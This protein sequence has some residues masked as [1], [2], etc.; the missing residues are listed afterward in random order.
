MT[1]H[2]YVA[3]DVHKSTTSVAFLNL[4]GNL[5]TQ[6]V[7]QTQ[8]SA[9]RDSLRGISG[10]VHLTFE[11]GAQSQRLFDLAR[12]LVTEALVCNAKHPSSV[13][14]KSDKIDALRLAQYLR[15]GLLKSVYH[16][17]AS[18]HTLKRLARVYD[19]ITADT[20][21]AMNRLKPPYASLGVACPAGRFTQ[22]LR[23][24]LKAAYV[25][26]TLQAGLFAQD[27]SFSLDH[28]Y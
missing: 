15:A 13:S 3:F 19:S 16:G 8:A 5:V 23:I 27:C 9:I 17:S 7:I 21:R 25:I 26:A 11:E 28:H 18:T 10:T 24:Y 6:A 20:T 22:S 1:D 14:N 12:P 2:K 4:A